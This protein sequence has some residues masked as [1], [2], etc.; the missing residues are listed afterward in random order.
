MNDSNNRYF[1]KKK[2]NGSF[3]ASV[4]ADIADEY[5]GVAVL[6][7]EGFLSSGEPVNIYT[8]QWIGDQKEDMMITTVD[9]DGNPV[10][11]RKNV[12]IE[13]TFVVSQRYVMGN[14][15]I[16][17]QSVHDRFVNDMTSNDI[18]IKSQYM[19]GAQAHCICLK[20]YKPSVIKLDR[21]VNSFIMGT[22]TLHTIESTKS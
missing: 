13:V 22:I 12:D 4:Y 3:D 17:V 14:I 20:E 2:V 21:G 19:G 11:V 16:D 15:E 10:V 9:E 5:N 1:L 18:W 8:E 7:M 6:K